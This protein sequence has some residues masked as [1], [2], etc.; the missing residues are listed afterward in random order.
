MK[1]LEKGISGHQ[2]KMFAILLMVFDHIRQMFYYAGAPLFFTMIGRSVLTIFLFTSVEGYHYTRDKKKYAFRLLL[3]YWM[4]NLL[5][6]IISLLFPLEPVPLLNNVFGTILIGVVVMFAVDCF[7]SKKWIKGAITLSIPLIPTLLMNILLQIK[8]E[9]ANNV[10]F[11]FPS[12]TVHEGGKLMILLAVFLY[13]FR[14]RRVLQLFSIFLASLASTG[15]DFY[16]LFTSNIQWM[17]MFSIVP[18]SLYNGT[19]GKGSKKFFYIFYPA[20]I[21]LLYISSYV[22]YTYFM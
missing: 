19:K 17:M 21:Y 16:G 18:I 4:M 10:Y 15:F 8:P 3:F 11:F 13:I 20:H 9:I 22:Y 14:E 12:Y 5:N 6:R 1:N 7:R 2:L